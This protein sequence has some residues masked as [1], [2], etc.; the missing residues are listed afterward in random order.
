MEFI[1]AIGTALWLGILTSISPCP[2]AANIA[3]ISFIGKRV[4]TARQVLLTGLLYTLGRT[5]AYLI[6]AA[7]LVT[8]LLTVKDISLSL[9]KYM[10][11]ALGPILIIVGMF[12]LEMIAFGTK[13]RGV[14]EKLQKRAES[15]G[16]W[17]AILLGFLFALSFCPVSAALFF[18]SLISL[19]L[20]Y[21]DPIALPV[22]YGIG[23]A[24]PVM[25]FAFIIAFSAQKIGR[26]YDLLSKVEYWARRI[27][28]V[29]FIIVG[30]Y[31][32]L[33]Y[34]FKVL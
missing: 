22:I 12:L 9:Q 10:N 18:G 34:I 6:L 20:Q 2:L 24:V 1:L 19:S 26:A 11:Q 27:T 13:G 25:I 4:K 28:G 3:A 15:G 17:T 30:I 31:Y 16:K 21:N 32:C 8:S 14:S 29:V 5:L 33:S 7:I 23:T